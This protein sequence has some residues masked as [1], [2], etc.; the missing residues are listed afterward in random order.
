MALYANTN[1]QR[2]APLVGVSSFYNISVDSIDIINDYSKWSVQ[3]QPNHFYFCSYPFLIS[4]GTK[5]NIMEYDAKSQM[6][7]RFKEAFIRNAVQGHSTDLFL[8]LT[9]RRKHLISDSLNQLGAR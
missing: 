3:T 5:M 6:A 2:K 4:L 1:F 9:I 7:Q 8:T